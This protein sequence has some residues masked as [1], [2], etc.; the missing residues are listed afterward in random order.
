MPDIDWPFP[1]KF[2]NSSGYTIHRYSFIFKNGTNNIKRILNPSNSL[3]NVEDNTE[4]IPNILSDEIFYP[5]TKYIKKKIAEYNAIP[6]KN[7]I[8]E[9]YFLYDKSNLVKKT[10]VTAINMYLNLYG[11]FSY[12]SG[13]TR[14]SNLKLLSSSNFLK[15]LVEKNSQVSNLK[16]QLAQINGSDIKTTNNK[17]H[18]LSIIKIGKKRKRQMSE[19]I[20]TIIIR[21]QQDFDVDGGLNPIQIEIKD[22]NITNL[23]KKYKNVIYKITPLGLLFPTSIKNN[24]DQI[25]ILAKNLSRVKKSIINEKRF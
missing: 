16:F 20:Q 18:H 25:F 23:L 11:S 17:I 13:K 19:L 1:E 12:F 10:F 6:T 2:F 3:I 22:N 9:S 14:S 24:T 21:A 8:K 4:T 7:F 15:F 5:V